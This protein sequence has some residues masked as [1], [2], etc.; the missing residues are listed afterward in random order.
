[1]V[2][3]LYSDNRLRWTLCKVCK[4]FQECVALLSSND[5]LSLYE[6]LITFSMLATV[7]GKSKYAE[8]SVRD[9]FSDTTQD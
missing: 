8:E 3:S 4:T 2:Y 9:V 1:M 6:F 5:W 7:E